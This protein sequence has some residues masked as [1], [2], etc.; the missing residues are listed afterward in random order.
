MFANDDYNIICYTLKKSYII[1]KII[2]HFNKTELT[3]CAVIL[4]LIC[5]KDDP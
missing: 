4:L 3:E 5:K 2:N 1:L